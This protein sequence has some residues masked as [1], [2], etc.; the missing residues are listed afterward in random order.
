MPGSHGLVAIAPA[1]PRPPTSTSRVAP[2]RSSRAFSATPVSSSAWR[3]IP[4]PSSG[5][6]GFHDTVGAATLSLPFP[7]T[8]FMPP[9]RDQRGGG[10]QRVRLLDELRPR[11]PPPLLLDRARRPRRPERQP[12]LIALP[13]GTDTVAVAVDPGLTTTP[14]PSIAH[15]IQEVTSRACRTGP[16]AAG[17]PSS[18]ARSASSTP[19]KSM[20]PAAASPPT[21]TRSRRTPARSSKPPTPRR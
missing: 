11:P 18:R 8:G 19:A 1:A 21:S 17:W 15:L 9:C 14:P 3:S 13:P 20:V 10:R 4:T 16:S 6:D 7:N 12:G 5:A 2:A